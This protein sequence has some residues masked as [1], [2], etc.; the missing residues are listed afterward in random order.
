LKLI[1]YTEHLKLK[2]K[3]RN[4]S[5]KLVNDIYITSNEKYFDNVTR[6]QIAIKKIKYKEKTRDMVICYD[7]FKDRVEIIT[8]HPLKTYQKI[9][10]IKSGRWKKL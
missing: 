7:E 10:R 6:H 4:I 3:L 5:K 8:I 9:H 1:K 2:I